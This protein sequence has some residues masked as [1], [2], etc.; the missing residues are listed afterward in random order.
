MLVD[1]PQTFVN[2]AGWIQNILETTTD[3]ACG[4]ALIH[5][6]AGSRRSS[7]HH[8]TDWHILYVI[9]GEMHYA[10]RKLGSGTVVKFTVKPG[11]AVRTGPR[12]EHW[13][14]FPKET[15][16]LSIS[17]LSRAHDEHEKDVVRVEWLDG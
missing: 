13:T 10:E 12:V 2:D 11:Q 14:T 1:L 3:P 5:C 6:Y 9:H 16:L 15:L 7:H 17:R 4:V 8:R